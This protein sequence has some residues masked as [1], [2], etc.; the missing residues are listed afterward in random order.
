MVPDCGCWLW[1]SFRQGLWRVWLYEE[2]KMDLLI[3]KGIIIC[4]CKSQASYQYF[5]RM[6]RIETYQDLDKI[7]WEETRRSPEVA[8]VPLIIH[9]LHPGHYVSC[10]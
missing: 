3:S 8:S 1:L 6:S 5:P 2:I 7:D 10:S 9:F 4:V